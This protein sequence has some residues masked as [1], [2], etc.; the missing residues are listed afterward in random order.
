MKILWLSH[1]IPYPPKGG[2]LQRAH[3]LLCE[4]A[5]YHQVDLLAFNQVALMKPLFASADA[6]VAEASKFFQGVCRRHH[7]V[8]IPADGL[9]LGRQ[10]LALRSL[11]GSP[12]NIRWLESE[13]FC[14]S[15]TRWVADT[16]YDVVHF[17]TISLVPY[18]DV[19]AG[20]SVTVLDHHNIESNMLVRRASKES[21]WLKKAYYFQEGL[22]LRRFER[23]YC[24][25]FDL[26]ITCSD[27]D[28]R[29][30]QEISPQSRVEAVPNAV[31]TDYFR[32]GVEESNLRLIFVGRLNWYPNSKAV[33]FIA[34]HLWP[35]LKSTW[36][37]VEFDIVGAHPPKAVVA[38]SKREPN[39]KVHGF[40]DDVRPLMSRAT[41]YICPISDGGGTKLKV[42]DA[43][44]M[45]KALIAHPI[46]CEGIEVTPD[47]NV[48]FAETP[49]DYV[50]QLL[51]ILADK[52]RRG[53]LGAAGRLLVESHYSKIAVGRRLTEL[54]ERT[55]ANR[56]LLLHT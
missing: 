25:M 29:A 12:Y 43:L 40:V 5:K 49:E 39:F 27:L 10:R 54:L 28:S 16:C 1:L 37:D 30:L 32:P 53:R 31:D 9:R 34:E 7:F 6:G 36:P 20:N 55:A 23:R 24:S 26:N 42:L 14:S 35:K 38:L 48:L 2:V 56:G 46:A 13:A 41:A 8:P 17:D 47:E 21:H 18:R 11:I 45:G 19:I 51:V 15:L 44:A 50:R 4:V 33:C 52:Y 3:H 22:R